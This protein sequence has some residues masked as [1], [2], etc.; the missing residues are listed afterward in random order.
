MS[1][2]GGG[3]GRASE[4]QERCAEA[5][6]YGTIR[7]VEAGKT[8]GE[9]RW[10]GPFRTCPACGQRNFY[11][12]AACTACGANLRALAPSEPPPP[13]P[14]TGRRDA[15]HIHN[16]RVA[17]VAGAVAVVAVA[18]GV[19]V[20]RSLRAPAWAPLP[21]SVTDS[22]PRPAPAST[23]DEAPTA[24]PAFARPEDRASYEKGRRLLAAGE[25]KRAVGPLG[26]AARGLPRDPVV[27]HDYGLALVRAGEEDRGL[28]QLERAS[29]LAPGIGTYRLDLIR[30]LLAAG[31][32]GPAA[33]E[34][35]EVLARDPAN[36]GA[37]ELLASLTGGTTPGGKPG[38]PGAGV[39]MDLGGASSGSGN[40]RPGQSGASFT[41]ED[42][43]R[44]AAAPSRPIRSSPVIAPTAPPPSPS[45]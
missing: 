2:D 6:R 24:L 35:Q 18:A 33:R 22:G 28:F 29:R 36:Q 14:I 40:A 39:T 43:A 8:G 45:L 10:S 32:R 23:P 38:E 25:A 21:G 1:K 9:R 19:L 17:M 7:K 5:F 41:N 13:A 16:R 30:A 4:F 15:D 44:G 27:A 42:L 34:L 12:R 37:A 11:G 20:Y 3:G 31:R 26:D